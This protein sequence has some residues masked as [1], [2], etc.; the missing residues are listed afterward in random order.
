MPSPRCFLI[1]LMNPKY[2]S[3]GL[4]LFISLFTF[5]S[6][7]FTMV[8]EPV[9]EDTS[10]WNVSPT[11]GLFFS[12]NSF[13]EYYKGGGVN[14]VALGLHVDLKANYERGSHTWENQLRMRYGGIKV[15]A[16]PVQKNEDIFE[17]NSKYGHSFSDHLQ[18][19]GLF[20]FETRIHD[21]YELKEGERGKLIGNFLAPAYI[22]MG[23]GVD[24]K[25]KDKMVSIYYSPLN[26][27]LTVVNDEELIPQYLGN[28]MGGSARYELGS[29]LKFDVKYKIM[30]NITLHSI[31]SLF[32]NHLNDFG[33]VDVNLEN[34]LK[35]KVNKFFSVNLLTQVIYDEDILFDINEVETPGGETVVEKGP[36]TQFRE[37][38]NIGLSH[39]F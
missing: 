1:K 21:V 11:L 22:N 34:N 18:V 6:T 23:S 20:S 7:S 29:L 32:T 30:E 35:F 33:K 36:R 38:L 14:S 39:T 13:S 28:Y 25:T 26:S 10:Y 2:L 37:V 27:K 17:M 4:F 5:Y 9:V 15:G 16:L 31:G 19:T 3:R 8:D 12:Q 24:F